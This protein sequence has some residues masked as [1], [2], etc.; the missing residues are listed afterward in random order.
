MT[1]VASESSQMEDNI[2]ELLECTEKQTKTPE[3]E[4]LD[5][6]ELGRSEGTLC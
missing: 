4:D 5:D 6:C 2:V 3:E 1:T